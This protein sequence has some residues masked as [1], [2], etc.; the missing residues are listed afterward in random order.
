MY[1]LY[2]L[3]LIKSSG[4]ETVPHGYD[5]MN[6]FIFWVRY[7]AYVTYFC[8]DGLKGRREESDKYAR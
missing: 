4:L 3:H 8:I 7:E 1:Y 6:T 5:F 2:V